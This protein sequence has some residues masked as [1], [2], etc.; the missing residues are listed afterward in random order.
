MFLNLIYLSLIFNIPNWRESAINI[1][2]SMGRIISQYP[3]S[4]GV[5]VIGIQALTEGVPEIL[6]TG[7]E[8]DELRAEF[9][10]IFIPYRIFQS[11]TREM[12][13][14]PL[15]VGKP[16]HERPQIYLCKNYTCQK[17]M[18]E[19]GELRSRLTEFG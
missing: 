1:F 7:R 15:T 2:L 3:L 9:L 8:I 13:H 18:S 5:W 4:F 11:V 19:L 14:L 6:M 16:I 10:H 12:N 17:P